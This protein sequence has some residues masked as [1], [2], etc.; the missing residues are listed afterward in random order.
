MAVFHPGKEAS[1]E[2]GIAGEIRL[3]SEARRLREIGCLD[4]RFEGTAADDRGNLDWLIMR[5]ELGTTASF[6]YTA[7]DESKAAF[8]GLGG[9]SQ[10]ASLRMPRTGIRGGFAAVPWAMPDPEGLGMPRIGLSIEGFTFSIFGT[11]ADCADEDSEAAAGTEAGGIISTRRWGS[12]TLAFEASFFLSEWKEKPYKGGW[13]PGTAPR[14]AGLW[15]G[16]AGA[17]RC[18]LGRASCA[19]WISGGFSPWSEPGLAAA[20]DL[21]LSGS[22]KSALFSGRS[23]AASLNLLAHVTLLPGFRNFDATIPDDDLCLKL[24]LSGKLGNFRADSSLCLSSGTDPGKGA[25]GRYR[26][27]AMYGGYL[28]YLATTW[29]PDAFSS[30]A[31]LEYSPFRLSASF[32]ALDSGEYS[33]GSNIRFECMKGRIFAL[34]V[35]LGATARTL[36]DPVAGALWVPEILTLDIAPSLHIPIPALTF[37]M[38]AGLDYSPAEGGGTDRTGESGGTGGAPRSIDFARLRLRVDRKSVV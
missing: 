7:R 33:F 32:S 1:A 36:P 6:R 26:S 38:S 11:A 27:I 18:D 37:L 28:P 3:E 10:T 4:F 9:M 31:S 15:F 23:W 5:A 24:A 34:T 19:A 35:S 21:S 29:V 14:P 16:G 17:A 25:A 30:R 12:E 20:V 13:R 2:S 8:A 22:G